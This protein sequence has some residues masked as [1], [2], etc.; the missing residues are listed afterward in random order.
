MNTTLDIKR[1]GLLFQRFFVENRQREITFWGISIFVFMLVRD[2]SAVE[3]FLMISGLIFAANMFKIFA[4]TP[5]GMHYLL[6]PATH[7]EKLV[8][9][10]LLSIVYYFCMFLVTYTIGTW[11]GIQL[12]NLLFGLEKPLTFSFYQMDNTGVDWNGQM[13]HQIGLLK[14]YVS[15]V[16]TQSI[17]LLGSIFFKRNS[18]GRTFLSIM[19][20]SIVLIIIQL[21]LIKINFGTWN[22]NIQMNN[23]IFL[24][25]GM[26]LFQNNVWIFKLLTYLTIPFL[27]LV[28]YFRLTE[29]EV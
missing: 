11:L 4:Y 7:A 5:G 29:K 28:S 3:M 27:W 2:N 22:M 18:V 25:S 12:G 24:P 21:F 26:K 15:F 13:V 8:S 14:T 23:T 1:L 9:S 19:A 6:I 10:I 20:I 16:I 17:F